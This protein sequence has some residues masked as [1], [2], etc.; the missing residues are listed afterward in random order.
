MPIHPI[1]SSWQTVGAQDVNPFS[2]ERGNTSAPYSFFAPRAITLVEATIARATA[3]G[4]GA[5][6]IFRCYDGDQR[7]GGSSQQTGSDVTLSDPNTS[8]RSNITGSWP[9]ATAGLADLD[10]DGHH[11]R[12]TVGGSPS[13][14]ESL[15]GLLYEDTADNAISYYGY[16]DYDFNI[17][18]IAGAGVNGFFT[19]GMSDDGS[20]TEADV[21]LP[22]PTPGTFKNLGLSYAVQ[23]GGADVTL[24]LRNGGVD[25]GLSKTLSDTS[26]N[27]TV[28]LDTTTEVT[29]SAGDL[30]NW[31]FVRADTG[32]F[33]CVLLLGFTAT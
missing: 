11:V 3:P 20:T 14:D 10:D 25:T 16:G 32:L 1:F 29:V 19:F 21:Q 9:A 27:Q 13:S 15:V 7:S 33:R 23:T 12:Y 30:L 6:N 4:S 28:L 24:V 8:V 5:S 17:G 26:G 22:W 18:S 31:R 2:G